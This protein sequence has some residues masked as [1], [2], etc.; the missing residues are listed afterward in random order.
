M[1]FHVFT[2]ASNVDTILNPSL[3]DIVHKSVH[4]AQQ[5]ADMSNLF[6]TNA[7]RVKHS[8]DHKNKVF[9]IIIGLLFSYVF[10]KACNF[11]RNVY[12]VTWGS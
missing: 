5:S 6:A 2:L 11:I 4:R 3:D 8:F 1:K 12:D 9:L 10:G 7:A